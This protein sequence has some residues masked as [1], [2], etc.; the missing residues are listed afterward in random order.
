VHSRADVEELRLTNQLGEFGVV[1]AILFLSWL[2]RMQMINTYV[3][4]G[5][6]DGSFV[7]RSRLCVPG[8]LA[9]CA[10]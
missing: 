7:R 8:L 4:V 10:V 5:K 2:A 1:G 6:W 3:N 9:V